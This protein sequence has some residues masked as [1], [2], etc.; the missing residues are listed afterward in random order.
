MATEHLN[1]PEVWKAIPD[2]LG[3][4]VSDHGRVR[5]YWNPGPGQNI[6]NLPQ[7]IL[8]SKLTK[9]GYPEVGL[10]KNLGRSSMLVHRL[11]LLAFVGP[12]PKGTEACHNDGNK[13]NNFL[14][15]L[16]WDTKSANGLESYKHGTSHT[17]GEGHPSAKLT[18][19]KVMEIRQ[20]KHGSLSQMDTYYSVGRNTIKRVLNRTTWKHI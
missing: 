2:Y 17:R 15:N 13:T 18:E 8:K 20:R 7:K 14:I 9:G 1:T 6:R 16:R 4:E 5:S 10:C 3:Y 12:C 19:G 11:V